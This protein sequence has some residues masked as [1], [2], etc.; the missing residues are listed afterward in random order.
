ME[1]Q[2]ES[3]ED[4][5]IRSHRHCRSETAYNDHVQSHWMVIECIPC[6]SPIDSI[7]IGI[8]PEIFQIAAQHQQK[9]ES[10][11]C[12]LSVSRNKEN[13]RRIE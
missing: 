11:E 4:D 7:E 12:R 9:G 1:I 3:N 10:G 6:I 2:R 8:E 5:A 13:R